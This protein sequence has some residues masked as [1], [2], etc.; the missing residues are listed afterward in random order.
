MSKSHIARLQQLS[1]IPLSESA[2][3]AL[4]G[5][6]SRYSDHTIVNFTIDEDKHRP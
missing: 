2:Q 5:G 6:A 3:D 4:N 1:G